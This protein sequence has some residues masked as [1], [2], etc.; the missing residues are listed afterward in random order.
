VRTLRL[1]AFPAGLALG[2]FA[3][4]AALRRGPLEQPTSAAELRL[5]VVDLLAGAVLMGAGLVVW[6]RRAGRVG[7]LLVLTGFAWFLGTFAGSGVGGY[8]DVGVLFLTLHRG[9]LVHALL[10]YPTGR[11]TGALER[12]VIVAVYA[13]AAVPDVAT[14]PEV[15]IAVAV[16]VVALG[17]RRVLEA[18]GPERRGRAA[19]AASAGAFGLVLCVSALVELRGSGV[20]AERGVLWAY[21]AVVAGIA[22]ALALH[23]LLGRWAQTTVTQL[24][25][26]LGKGFPEGAL[27]D[28]L[29]SAL[30]DRSLIFG[31]WLPERG[32]YVDHRGEVVELPGDGRGGV[33][34]VRQG[35]EPLAVLVHDADRVDDAELLE[36]VAAAA[37]VAVV[38]MQ[39]QEDVRRQVAE[40]AAS[41]RRIVDAGDAQRRRLETEIRDGAERTL[42]E[43]ALL[44]AELAPGARGEFAATLM[45]TE[46]ELAQ[47]RRELREFARGIHPRVLTEG[48]LAAALRELASR[49]R[50]PVNL[51]VAEVRYPASIEAATYFVCAEAVTN[52]GKYAEAAH[53][54]IDVAEDGASLVV[55]VTDDGKGGAYLD[56]ASGLRGLADRVEAL[57]GRFALVSRLGEGTR[58]TAE[59]PLP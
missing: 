11:A 49:S 50:V 55:V 48:G 20:F 58:V 53:V 42:G 19:A 52:V 4:W 34:V 25:V 3:E 6:E 32:V 45:E 13:V 40:L 51:S 17:V 18:G 28:R 10:S 30:G 8:A 37:R 9:P 21:D 15:A 35:S 44:L 57:G 39:L 14:T 33:T 24:V 36:S 5:A 23:L 22:A 41:R 46:D 2:L 1:A 54:A 38:N 12:S 56:G 31:Y 16:L 43:A 47:A 7:P 29:A 26:D 27:R 59:L